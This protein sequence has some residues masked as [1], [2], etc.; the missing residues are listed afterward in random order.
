M[1]YKGT[2]VRIEGNNAILMTETCGFVT[3]RK[4]PGMYEGLEISF[5][6]SEIIRERKRMVL[7]S[8]MAAGIAAIF[9][10]VFLYY[11]ILYWN[12]IYAYI[13]IDITPSVELTI[14]KESKVLDVSSLNQDA[15]ILIEGMNLKSKPL[16]IALTEVILESEQ[17]GFIDKTHE[18]LV[19]VS[20]ALQE[21]KRKN[22]TQ[23]VDEKFYNV[24]ASCKLAIN[25][26]ENKN[27]QPRVLEIKPEIRKLAVKNKISM[28]RYLL[29]EKANEQ[30]IHMNIDEARVKRIDELFKKVQNKN[31]P[32]TT[33]GEK[34]IST[35]GVPG[36]T[37]P[38]EI[39]ASQGKQGVETNHTPD[40]RSEKANTGSAKP[41][42]AVTKPAQTLA[43]VI[44]EEFIGA[45]EQTPGIVPSSEPSS[46]P[47]VT[48]GN[49]PV[50]IPVYTA[51]PARVD[52]PRLPI[53]SPKE[54][55]VP[56]PTLQGD[57]V[58]SVIHEIEAENEKAQQEISNIKQK[59]DSDI[60][61]LTNK[62]S[63]QIEEIMRNSNIDWKQKEE[64]IMKIK[65]D[66][67]MKVTEI[68][69]A[70]MEQIKI[71][72]DKLKEKTNELI[73]TTLMSDS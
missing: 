5:E 67:E 51:S 62:A 8:S 37:A 49:P 28:G 44:P 38:Q 52:S 23:K 50:I 34:E 6:K 60:T 61:S 39:S 2:I 66:L 1:I 9:I 17:C 35:G 58:V 26:L 31:I 13:D 7:Y 11:K 65:S 27:I 12:D 63:S 48:P 72:T 54:N 55:E 40:H 53:P 64:I 42:T 30:G 36:S 71:I 29:Y 68:N 10:F 18:N 21:D 4:Q 20:V 15:K 57:D 69:K 22:P 25:S 45:W 32:D 59:A 14:D 47:A 3:I 41:G 19:L 24:L 43:P 46:I 16:N 33:E 56:Y 73:S 70:A